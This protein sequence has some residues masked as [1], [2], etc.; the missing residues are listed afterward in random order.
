MT[1]CPQRLLKKC[2]SSLKLREKKHT[3]LLSNLKVLTKR[4]GLRWMPTQQPLTKILVAWGMTAGDISYN[5]QNEPSWKGKKCRTFSKCFDIFKLDTSKF[6]VLHSS[7]NSKIGCAADPTVM[8]T[9]KARF[10]TSP[11]AYHRIQKVSMHVK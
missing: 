1:H 5:Q 11:Q 9:I 6:S 7:K 4:S 10:F 3:R 8:Y 2:L